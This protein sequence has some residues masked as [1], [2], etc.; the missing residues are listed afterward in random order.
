MRSLSA[1]GALPVRGSQ[2]S[3][4][5]HGWGR[6]T[7]PCPELWSPAPSILTTRSSTSAPCLWHL[8]LHSLPWVTFFNS[9]HQAVCQVYCVPQQGPSTPDLFLLHSVSFPLFLSLSSLLL[10]TVP[11][12]RGS[13]LQTIPDSRR[14]TAAMS[15]E[16]LHPLPCTETCYWRSL[17]VLQLHHPAPLG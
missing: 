3:Q 14:C 12:S 6:T 2:S 1:P 8:T 4:N 17:I 11:P 7:F 16:Y 15:H 10:T 13:T 5:M 9:D